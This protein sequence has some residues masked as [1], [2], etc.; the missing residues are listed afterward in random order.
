MQMRLLNK[1]EAWKI[2]RN[3]S[4]ISKHTMVNDGAHN[5]RLKTYYITPVEQ[6]KQLKELGFSDTKMYGLTDG[7]EIKN[8]TTTMD[9]W[10]Y[11]LSKVP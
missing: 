6:L 1:K 2:I 8:P 11:F 10:I 3:P 7:R 4:K 9:Q 5:F